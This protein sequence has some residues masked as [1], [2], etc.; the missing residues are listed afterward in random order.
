M[1][2][3]S[4]TARTIRLHDGPEPELGAADRFRGRQLTAV[5]IEFAQTSVTDFA[6][7]AILD[8]LV[9]RIVD[10]LPVTAA[11]VTLIVPGASPR[12]IAASN[13]AAMEFEQ[14]QSSTGE[15]PCVL[16]Y[17]SGTA[18]SVPDLRAPDERFPAFTAA[19]DGTSLAA[20]FTFPLRH[21]TGQLGALDLYRD[22]PGTLTEADF[23]AAQTLADVATA[24][25][26]NAQGRQDLREG[27]ER[28][29]NSALHDALT[30]VP[31][32]LL[33]QQRLEHAAE[34]AQ[35]TNGPAAV[36]FAD[37]D[38]FKRVNDTHGHPVG[39]ALLVA[40]AD[41]LAALVRP[42]D[43]LARVSGDEFVTLCEDLH[44]PVDVETLALRLDHAFS[45]PFVLPRAENGPMHISVTA[46]IG[47]AFAGSAEH[48]GHRLV[49]D[50]DVS[51][52]PSRS[53]AADQ[54]RCC[55]DTGAGP[56][57]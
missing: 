34:R 30:G 44:D 5:L 41:R 38:A 2:A 15:G 45:P 43:T 11:G 49:S 50:A 42:G 25:L 32:R 6:I 48:I 18:V 21:D 27:A 17:T 37:L 22:T 4:V 16:A 8:H 13:D 9:E 33:L 54:A 12:Y 20:V 36:L 47:I 39:D 56:R 35:R 14:L 24:Y 31:N 26:L 57:R 29:G 52:Y 55:G 3:A 46:S 23:S 53:S 7:Q 19:G 10:V 51:A 28:S 1:R 40:V